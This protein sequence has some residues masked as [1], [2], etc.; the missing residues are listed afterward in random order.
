MYADSPPA[1][2]PGQGTRSRRGATV[3][4]RQKIVSIIDI[5]N[6]MQINLKVREAMVSK[7]APNMKARVKVDAFPDSELTGVVTEI[8]PRPDPPNPFDS[9]H[10]GLHHPDPARP[11]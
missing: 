9:G 7:L 5:N 2:A 8:A 4:E 6:P 11:G 1:P 10:Q 3:R